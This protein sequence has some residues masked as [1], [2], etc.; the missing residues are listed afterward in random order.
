MFVL[1][2]QFMLLF[3]PVVGFS[4]TRHAATRTSTSMDTRTISPESS[5]QKYFP[6]R[7]TRGVDIGLGFN[8]DMPSLCFDYRERKLRLR[9]LSSLDL[10]ASSESLP[11]NNN[12]SSNSSHGTDRS[13]SAA[14]ANILTSSDP[15]VL[16]QH[17][18]T[19]RAE[20][21]AMR[22]QIQ[23]SKEEAERRRI[24]RVDNMISDILVNITIDENNEV[25]NTEEQVAKMMQDG[26]LNA[27][28]VNAMFDRIVQQSQRRQ[29]IDNCSP[30]ISLLLDAACMVDCMEREANPNKRWN[31]R[32]ERDL[33]KK[34]FALGWGIDIDDVRR[35]DAVRSITGEK[36][37]Y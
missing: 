24:A 30:L 4:T 31:H 7:S 14:S 26:R 9:H 15:I 5:R 36:D 37:V 12:N 3:T 23:Q 25:L 22:M 32:V 1:A 28:N 2:A 19:L 35:D 16:R 13:N 33:R 18:E 17:A 27:D 21:D 10:S 6:K 20:A 8:D 29:S 34:L 11:D